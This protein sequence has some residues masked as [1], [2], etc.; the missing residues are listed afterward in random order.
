MSALLALPLVLGFP[1]PVPPDPLRAVVAPRVEKFLAAHKNA[2]VVVGVWKDGTPH[3]FGFGTVF[4]PTGERTPDGTTVFEIGSVTKALTGVLLAEAVRRGEVKLDAP[5]QNYLPP[6]LVLPKVGDAPITLE[7]LATHYSGL[8]AE[9]PFIGFTA[10]NGANPYADYDRQKLARMLAGLKPEH[11][12]GEKHDYSNLGT[13]LVGHALVH[14]AKADSFDALLRERLC[15]PLGLKD[16]GEALTGEQRSRSARGHEADGTPT[17]HWDF[18][19]LEACGAVRSTAN[20]MLR[21]AAAAVGD[22]E[23]ELLPAIRDSLK[24]RKK[25]LGPS[26]IGLFWLVTP[27]PGRPPDVWHNGSTF[28]HHAMLWLVP[29]AKTAVVVLSSVAADEVDEVA[30]DV[31]HLVLPKKK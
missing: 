21:F 17:P 3:V 9:P 26:E 12:P 10:K 30:I 29:G 27:T 24:P 14:V 23:T 18:A 25:A 1:S 28:A 5:A 11:K 15:K 8:P 31:A 16:T 20:D 2:G 6:D 19:S 13:G 4:L 7:D 22:R